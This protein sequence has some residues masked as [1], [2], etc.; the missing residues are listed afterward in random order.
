MVEANGGTW[1]G[2]LLAFS[3]FGQG[4]AKRTAPASALIMF[5]GGIGE[6]AFPY[7]LIKPDVWQYSRFMV[8]SNFPWRHSGS[9]FTRQF[10]GF[11]DDVPEKCHAGE[12]YLLL[13]GPSCF[14]FS[15]QF[16]LKT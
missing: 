12:Y 4:V 15:S 2:L 10:F 5:F 7:A 9:R 16:L 1:T 6:I 13:C 11:S 14:F 8:G 3:L